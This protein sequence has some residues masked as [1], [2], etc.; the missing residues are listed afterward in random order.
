ML[1]CTSRHHLNKAIT[2]IIAVNKITIKAM[3]NNPLLLLKV[4]SNYHL[5]ACAQ[6]N[7]R[8]LM[9]QRLHHHP[10]RE[11][12]HRLHLLWQNRRE[13]LRHLLPCP[14][15]EVHH[16]HR[17]LPSR[18]PRHTKTTMHLSPVVNEMRSCRRFQT[19]GREDLKR[20]KQTTDRPQS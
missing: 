7:H 18:R 2:M 1:T 4:H 14:K 11:R 17:P 15:Q 20:R 3:L 16:L 10:S 12:V 6:H 8:R 9:A 19:S 5:P 13:D